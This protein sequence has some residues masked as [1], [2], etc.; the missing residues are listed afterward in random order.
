MKKSVTCITA[1]LL[2]LF[3]FSGCSKETA[4]SKSSP[5]DDFGI[6]N[7][8][9]TN[10]LF[11]YA[12]RSFVQGEISEND[13][14]LILD[15]GVQAPSARNGQPWHFT[16]LRDNAI[17]NRIIPDIPDGNIL[18]IVSG[19]GNSSS[20]FF[21]CALATE[22]M[23]LA[24]QALGLGSRIYTGPISAINANFKDTLEIP[25]GFDAISLVR[26]GHIES[27]QDGMSTASPRLE[28]ESIIN[29]K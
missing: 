18:I 25:A 7:D 13:L 9:I 6:N 12:A 21:D 2:V 26:I 16:V 19:K 4:G 10:M 3:V 28:A 24:A 22:N 8:A 23:Y 27:N 20:V 1:T 17:A 29:Y 15:C 11:N 5:A 14:S